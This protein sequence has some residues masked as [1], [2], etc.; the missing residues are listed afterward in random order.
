MRILLAM[1]PLLVIA[2]PALAQGPAAPPPRIPPQLT[3]PKMA[4]R[5]ADTMQSLSQAL[6][7][8]PV[9]EVQAAVEGRAPTPAEKKLTVRDLGRRDDR[10]FDRNFRR[11]IA[12]ARPAI[13][14]GMKALNAALPAV[15]KALDDAGRAID[16][17]AANMPDPTYPKR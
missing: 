14:H 2:S 7:N 17:A 12:Q 10:D 1:I 6:L 11:Q 9:G 4:D 16:R 8:L 13:E 3:D 5:L 15:M